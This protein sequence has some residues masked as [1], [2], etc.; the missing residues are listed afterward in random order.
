MK[1]VAD[2]PFGDPNEGYARDGV[3]VSMKSREAPV[4]WKGCFEFQ[5]EGWIPFSGSMDT[6]LNSSILVSSINLMTEDYA[7]EFKDRLLI[8]NHSNT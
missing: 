4:G 1:P 5:S 8:I 7:P 6:A 2:L 3:A